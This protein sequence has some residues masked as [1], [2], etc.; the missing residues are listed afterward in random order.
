M[1]ENVEGED[2]ESGRGGGGEAGNRRGQGRRE[3]RLT[4]QH[5]YTRPTH[6]PTALHRRGT[7]PPPTRK[8]YLQPHT[9]RRWKARLGENGGGKYSAGSAGEVR[10]R[11][12]AA[13]AA[14][15]ASSASTQTQSV[16]RGSGAL[17]EKKRKTSWT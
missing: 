2:G 1:Q 11:L 13:A 5:V 12:P 16:E 7:H 3:A 17:K 10:R 4:M 8:T 9:R 6:S 15:A 14:A